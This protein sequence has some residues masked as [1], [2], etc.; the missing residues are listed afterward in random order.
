MQVYLYTQVQ[1]KLE[2][3]KDYHDQHSQSCEFKE[4]ENM[5]VKDFPEEKMASWNYFKEGRESYIPHITGG[6]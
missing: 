3:Q 1:Q 6:W 4:G 5:Y 2:Q